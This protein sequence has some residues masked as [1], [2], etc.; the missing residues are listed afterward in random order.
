MRRPPREV[1][2]FSM[3]A[4]DVLAM[5][6]GVFVL[7]LVMMIP[8]YRKTLDAEARLQQLRATIIATEAET[9]AVAARAAW[10]DDEAEALLGEVSH[11]TAVAKS[12][13]QRA[14]LDRSARPRI[15][16]PAP[17]APQPSAPKTPPVPAL[18][19]P[20][21]GELDLVF[22]IDRTASMTPAIGEL[23]LDL[24]SIVR[25]LERLVPSVRIGVVAYSDRDTGQNP[26]TVLPLTATTPSLPRILQFVQ[27]LRASSISSPTPE[28]DDYLGLQTAVTFAYRPTAIQSLVLIGDAA[29][30]PEEV[31]PA[32]QLV[33]AFVARGTAA[34]DK[35]TVSALFVTT[36]G[37]LLR[38]QIDRSFFQGIAAAGNGTFTD[39]AGSMI[40]SVLASVLIE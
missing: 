2:T 6:T 25:V 38:G 35:R 33:R 19:T 39:H 24:S 37:S 8:Y 12:L 17:P 14:D 13:E 29:A 4:L 7:L 15:P 9:A 16:K 28:E 21:A 31:A 26:I 30:H 22:V 5:S 36:P 3:S 23:A 11:L 20:V 32:L 18:G 10:A 1:T 34:G 40:D 27:G